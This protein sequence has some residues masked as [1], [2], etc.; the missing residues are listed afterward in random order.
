MDMLQPLRSSTVKVWLTGLPTILEA[1]ANLMRIMS[2][3]SR[4]WNLSIRSAVV[5]LNSA[6]TSSRPRRSMYTGRPPCERSGDVSR[7]ASDEGARRGGGRL[8]ASGRRAHLVAVVVE[9]GVDLH[10][11]VE[12]LELEALDDAVGA[13][14]G[15]PPHRVLELR[16]RLG[17]VP[18]S[19]AHEPAELVV[20]VEHRVPRLQHADLEQPRAEGGELSLLLAG[21]RAREARGGQVGRRHDQA[22]LFLPLGLA[23]R[24]AQRAL[25]RRGAMGGGAPI[26]RAP[27]LVAHRAVADRAA[28]RSAV[29][30]RPS[31]WPAAPL[32]R[33]GAP[34]AGGGRPAGRALE[35]ARGRE[36]EPGRALGA[37]RGVA[38]ARRALALSRARPA[39]RAARASTRAP[40][41]RFGRRRSPI[42]PPALCGRRPPARPRARA[43]ARPPRQRR[44]AVPR[45]RVRR[46]PAAAAEAVSRN[47]RITSRA[48]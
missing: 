24:L 22:H 23:C 18:R 48:F 4:T 42:A 15:A 14:V 11:P 35:R 7:R 28:G 27:P 3:H 1:I 21:E 45:T 13:E 5:V 26:G 46:L 36:R 38:G 17:D 25:R 40:L 31:E 33:L 39:G 20:G 47:I 8:G 30:S 41:S 29:A 16:G 44:R 10:H 43:P 12:F 2:S 34:R 37:G 6:G 19:R 9:L 32:S